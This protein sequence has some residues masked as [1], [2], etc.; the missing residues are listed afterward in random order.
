MGATA[1]TIKSFA[2][3]VLFSSSLEDKLKAPSISVQLDTSTVSPLTT[4]PDAPGRPSELSLMSRGASA[5]SRFPSKTSLQED[6]SRGMVLHFFANHELLALEI[7]ALALLKW[8]DAPLGFRKG[9]VQTMAEEQSHLRLYLQRMTELGVKFGEAPV[10]AFFWNSLK[11]MSSPL[12]Y[13]AAMSMTFEQANLDFSLHYESTFSELGDTTTAEIMKRVRLEEIGHVKHGVVWFERWRPKTERLFK[14]WYDTLTFPITPARAKG[15]QLDREGRRAA[16]LTED[17]IDELAVHN[18]SKGRPP[19]VL[20]FNPGCESEVE[21]GSSAWTAPQSIRQ[22]ACDY[23][24]LMSFIAHKHDI[25]MTTELPSVQFLSTLN[26][27]GF[28]VPEF[29]AHADISRLKNRKI[30]KFVPWGWSPAAKKYFAPLE[31]SLLSPLKTPNL[32]DATSELCLFSKFTAASIR[33]QL[34]LDSLPRAYVSELETI[35]ATIENLRKNQGHKAIVFKTPFSTSGRGMCRVLSDS[36]KDKELAWLKS[37]IK[38]HGKVLAEP[39]LDKVADLS[40]HIDILENGDVHFVGLTRFWTTSGG[41]YRGHILG[42][43][44]DDFDTVALQ[45]WHDEQQGW[46]KTL[47]ETALEIGQIAAKSGYFGPLGI[48]A[49]IYRDKDRLTLRPMIE[50]NPRWSMGR[51]ALQLTQ[52]IASKHCGLWIHLSKRDLERAGYP[53]FTELTQALKKLQP[54][55]LHN[56]N[57][58]RVIRK[59]VYPMNDP[60]RAKHALALLVVGRDLSECY[61]TL[62]K[63]GIYDDYLE[64]R[65]QGEAGR[66]VSSTET[67]ASRP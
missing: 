2:E 61:D 35:D 57:A 25:V 13:A 5:K 46:Q 17:F 49:F 10:N 9:I 37:A 19:K 65:L 4:I 38:Q 58:Q 66:Y 63:G 48:D 53:G 33:E 1:E 3:L 56:P 64:L 55:D 42:R 21:A 41:Q 12:E 40:A 22:L 8:P 6:R 51:I 23:E 20:M 47:R 7:M 36:P 27:I 30:D 14:E 52:K 59:G 31:S 50:L 24:S 29:V 32:G 34:K 43:V 15:I 54:D 28:D 11:S 44:M 62:R 45:Q 16:G 26:A 18:Q 60:A 39:W 67:E